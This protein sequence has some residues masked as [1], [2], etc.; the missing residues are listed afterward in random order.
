MVFVRRI[1]W[2]S[3]ASIIQAQE[4]FDVFLGKTFRLYL[5]ISTPKVKTWFI[6]CNGQ[7]LNNKAGKVCEC[8]EARN[9]CTTRA[10]T[11]AHAIDKYL[12]QERARVRA[13]ATPEHTSPDAASAS[14]HQ[15]RDH[16]SSSIS[17]HR[18]AIIVAWPVPDHSNMCTQ[19]CAN[20]YKK[21]VTTTGPDSSVPNCH[22]Y[23]FFA[24]TTTYLLKM[25]HASKI[26][27]LQFS[28]FIKKCVGS[29]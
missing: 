19:T 27:M 4:A 24:R 9:K 8:P 5:N 25:C 22:F 3:L 23:S 2:K 15:Y 13:I 12:R 16:S 29:A 11:N 18:C 17:Q 21:Y 14:Y 1:T 10:N 7:L 26:I 6:N 20:Q 28:F